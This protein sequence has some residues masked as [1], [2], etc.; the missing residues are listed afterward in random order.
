M[1]KKNE[2]YIQLKQKDIKLLREKLLKEQDY[3]CPIC[4]EKI[5]LAESTLDHQHKLFKD[6][7]IGNNGAGLCRGVICFRCNAWEGKIFNS[8]RRLGLHK[9]ELDQATLLRNLADYLEQEN[10]IYIHPTEVEKPKKLGKRI[11]NKLKKEY[12]KKYPNRK[13]LE[14][15]KSGK[16]TKEIEKIL[17]EF[18]LN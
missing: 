1:N 9:K 4:K 13:E 2:D 6:E 18:D 8:Y 5:T 14:Y 17:T 11:F 15:P 7:E 12:N 16:I 10:M 3:I